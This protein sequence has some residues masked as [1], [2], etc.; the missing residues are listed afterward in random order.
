MPSADNQAQSQ[1]NAA[2]DGAGGDLS[3]AFK[4]ISL[5]L[6]QVLGAASLAPKSLVTSPG[7]TAV[8]SPASPHAAVFDALLKAMTGGVDPSA[9]ATPAAPSTPSAS[10]PTAAAPSGPL[11]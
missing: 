1:A 2:A 6:P 7:A 5:R 4:V 3:S 9:F 11:T 8:S 10:A